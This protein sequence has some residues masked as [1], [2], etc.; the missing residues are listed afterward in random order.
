[1]DGEKQSSDDWKRDIKLTWLDP[2]KVYVA[3]IR[4][5]DNFT[6]LDAENAGLIRQNLLDSGL[7]EVVV[8]P[9]AWGL[10]FVEREPEASLS[11]ETL[12]E[13]VAELGRRGLVLLT[14]AEV[15]Q[16]RSPSHADGT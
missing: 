4:L 15:E 7:R 8:I 3:V 1:M 12:A 6:R 9:Q 2:H 5:P 11:D 10:E 16:L 13:A 14:Q